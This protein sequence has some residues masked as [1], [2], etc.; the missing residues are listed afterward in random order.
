[1]AGLIFIAIPFSVSSVGGLEVVKG[2]LEDGF[3]S[4]K[5]VSW[6]QLV[7]WMFTIIPIWFIGMTLYQRIYASKDKKTLENLLCRLIQIFL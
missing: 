2:T 3:L 4:L 1:M 7:N 6:Q 5:N